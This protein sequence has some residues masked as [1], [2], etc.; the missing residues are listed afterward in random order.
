MKE[1][2]ILNFR[3]AL[4]KGLYKAFV[5]AIGYNSFSTSTYA[6]GTSEVSLE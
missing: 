3:L 6:Q 4:I 2:K 5:L 1:K